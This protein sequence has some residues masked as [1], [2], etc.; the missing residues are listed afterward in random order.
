M[1]GKKV[2][3]VSVALI[4]IMGMFAVVSYYDNSADGA[5]L[6]VGLGDG[7]GAGFDTGVGD[8]PFDVA[9]ALDNAVSGDTVTLP[10]DAT[11][12]RDAT[13]KTGVTL[14]DDGFSLTVPAGTVLSVSDGGTFVSTGALLINSGGSVVSFGGTISMDG[15]SVEVTGSLEIYNEGTINVGQN[16]SSTLDVQ[17][18]GKLLVD[19]TMN[20]GGTAYSTVIIQTATITGTLNISYGSNFDVF[21]TLTIGSAPTLTTELTNNAVVAGVGKILIENKACIVVYGA[22]GFGPA[23][24]KN[25]SVV[26]TVFQS[27]GGDAFATEYKDNTGKR[28]LVIPSTTGLKDWSLVSWSAGGNII[29]ANTDIQIG[30][31]P[32]VIGSWTPISYN[33]TFAEDKNIIWRVNGID[34]G[35]SYE[36]TGA[37]NSSFT[38]SI[39]SAP[40]STGQMPVIYV[41]GVSTGKTQVTVTV[42]GNTTFT[43]SNHYVAKSDNTMTILLV[44]LG[45]MIVILALVLIVYIM[46]NRKK[47]K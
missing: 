12:S 11:L 13:I 16:V 40:K 18:T 47:D 14:D 3:L 37:F 39:S 15:N 24:I 32:T 28:A 27:K 10:A 29:T 42:T 38:V 5:G 2:L 9:S 23:N 22:S 17:G 26:S 21:D 30:A 4:A 25:S 1:L 43:T 45:V 41:D 19:G 6:G 7:Y 34:R 46:R 36:T 31:Y 8:S 20:V 33:V 44:V 35:S